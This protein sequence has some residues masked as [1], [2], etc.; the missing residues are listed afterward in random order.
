M[1]QWYGRVP[2]PFIKI[3]IPNKAPKMN[4]PNTKWFSVLAFWGR[5]QSY[6]SFLIHVFL[7]DLPPRNN[8]DLTTPTQNPGDYV[9]KLFIFLLPWDIESV[10]ACQVD[11]AIFLASPSFPPSTC[12]LQA[13]LQIVNHLRVFGQNPCP[14]GST[15]RDFQYPVFLSESSRKV[16]S[17]GSKRSDQ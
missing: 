3:N 16:K 15:P 7:V 5:D 6:R 17:K 10:I 11:W 14:G 2:Y 8:S 13:H 1:C 12:L 9:L 4:R